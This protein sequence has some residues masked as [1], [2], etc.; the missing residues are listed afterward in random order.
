L[1]GISHVA[2]SVPVGTLTEEFRAEVLRFYGGFLGWREVEWLRRAD[3]LTIAVGGGDYVN[4]RERVRSAEYS[5][6]EHFGLRLPSAEAVE[7]AW[8]ALAADGRCAELDPLEVGEDT[9]RHFRFRY[10]L[11]MSVEVQHLP[12]EGT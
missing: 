8:A 7:A 1:R 10:L 6:Y 11:P 9:Y 5:G 4:V 12:S 2:M 3:R